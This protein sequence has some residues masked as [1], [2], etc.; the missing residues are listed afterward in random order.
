L[1]ELLRESHAHG[2]GSLGGGMQVVDEAEEQLRYAATSNFRTAS[3]MRLA[4][5]R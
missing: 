2:E 1:K 5:G 3:T 4:S